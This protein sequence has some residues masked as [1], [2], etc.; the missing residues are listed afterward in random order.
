MQ[1]NFLDITQQGALGY[2]DLQAQN[3]TA[4][5]GESLDDIINS[6]RTATS[7]LNSKAQIANPVDPNL[8]SVNPTEV[9]SGLDGDWGSSMWDDSK[10]SVSEDTFNNNL[11]DERA[12]NQWGIAQ[13]GAGLG[14]MTTTGLTTL[15]NGTVGT[16][17]GIG[18][19]LSNLADDDENTGFMQGLWD[20]EF[21]KAMSAAQEKMEEVLPNYYSQEELESPWYTNVLSANFWGDKV[22]KNTGFT[23]GAIGAMWLTGG[24]GAIT[25]GLTVGTGRLLAGLAARGG[26]SLGTLRNIMTGAGTTGKLL[27]TLVNAGIAANG[28]ASFEAVNAV[29]ENAELALKNLEDKR[30]SEIQQLD[31][32]ASDYAE[33]IAQINKASEQYKEDIKASSRDLGNFVWGCNMA[34]LGLSDLAE[35][36]HI[37]QGGYKQSQKLIKPHFQS[38][39]KDASFFDALGG[40]VKG[41]K[42]QA[43]NDV[44]KSL[45]R[46]LLLTGKNALSE[47]GE[48]SSQNIVSNSGQLQE[49]ALLNAKAEQYKYNDGDT[50]LGSRI[51]PGATADLV[52]Y[53][54]AFTKALADQFGG[55]ERGGWEEGF[56]GALTGGAGFMSVT[57][58]Q[59]KDDKGELV[60]GKDGKPKTK[61]AFTWEGGFAEASRSVENE[62]NDNQR[63][64]DAI[65]K[66]FESPEFKQRLQHTIA[67]MDFGQRMDEAL[68][69]GDQFDFKNSE[70]G[71]LVEDYFFFRD[72]G[73]VDNLKDKWKSFQNIDDQTLSQLYLASIDKDGKTELEKKE[74][75]EIRKK[76][77]DKATSNLQKIQMIQD[78]FDYVDAKFPNY[79]DDFKYELAYEYIK[80]EDAKNRIESILKKAN[81]NLQ[82]DVSTMKKLWYSWNTSIEQQY[83]DGSEENLDKS[84]REDLE[85]LRRRQKRAF[86]NIKEYE[87]TPEKL[88]TK[89]LA[90]K[91]AAAL[92]QQN[93]DLDSL[94]EK[95]KGAE[96]VG[97]VADMFN[98]VGQENL[99]ALWERAWKT[100]DD[101]VRAKMVEWDT[102]QKA[103]NAM[104]KDFKAFNLSDEHHNA[105]VNTLLGLFR[106]YNYDSDSLIEAFVNEFDAV[107]KLDYQNSR[108]L[109]AMQVDASTEEGNTLR[110]VLRSLL[111]RSIQHL[112]ESQAEYGDWYSRYQAE[113][114]HR[115]QAEQQENDENSEEEDSEVIPPGANDEIMRKPQISITLDYLKS[116]SY[117]FRDIAIL[118]ED[119]QE[120]K[121]KDI[122]RR[123]L[124]LLEDTP[125]WNFE[126]VDKMVF[127]LSNIAVKQGK[128]ALTL[129]QKIKLISA[130]HDQVSQNSKVKDWNTPFRQTIKQVVDSYNGH[131]YDL[132]DLGPNG[133]LLTKAPDK[134]QGDNNLNNGTSD[135]YQAAKSILSD[136]QMKAY[137]KVE[138]TMSDKPFDTSDQIA[139]ANKVK[140]TWDL[141][142]QGKKIPED[143]QPIAN[144]INDSIILVQGR[145]SDTPEV[146]TLLISDKEMNAEYN[147]GFD[148]EALSSYTLKYITQESNPEAWK[149]VNHVYGSFENWK[150]TQFTI[151]NY[152]RELRKSKV[153][154]LCS[155]NGGKSG[156]PFY[157]TIFTAVKYEGSIVKQINEEG[158]KDNVWIVDTDDGQYLIIG[159]IGYNGTSDTERRAFYKKVEEDLAPTSNETSSIKQ[160]F[161]VGSIE[162]KIVDIGDG[163]MIDHIDGKSSGPQNLF[164]LLENKDTN[165][166]GLT[167]NDL[168]FSVYYSD[169]HR[170]TKSTGLPVH[171][172]KQQDESTDK[173]KVYVYIP[174]SNGQSYRHELQVSTYNDVP[175]GTPLRAK[176]EQALDNILSGHSWTDVLQLQGLLYTE[177]N[178]Y[179][180]FNPTSP[181]VSWKSRTDE[182][183]TLPLTGSI[184]EQKQLI[185]TQVLPSLNP[186]VQ[187]TLDILKNEDSLKMLAD[188]NCLNTTSAMMLGTVGANYTVSMHPEEEVKPT[189]AHTPTTV[190]GNSVKTTV[191]IDGIPV[192]IDGE[193]AAV[194]NGVPLSPWQAELLNLI[195][196]C[197]AG[198]YEA[199]QLVEKLQKKEKIYPGRYYFIPNGNSYR[200][201]HQ[202]DHGNWKEILNNKKHYIKLWKE[203][204]SRAAQQQAQ[205]EAASL[206]KV[207]TIDEGPQAPVSVSTSLSTT[208]IMSILTPI[209]NDLPQSFVQITE[210]LKNSSVVKSADVV[211]SVHCTP[212]DLVT[213]L[214]ILEAIGAVGDFDQNTQSRQV[215]ASS[216][217]IQRIIDVYNSMINSEDDSEDVFGGTSTDKPEKKKDSPEVPDFDQSTLDTIAVNNLFTMLAFL[218]EELEIEGA[219]IKEWSQ[220]AEGY[221]NMDIA[222]V[223]GSIFHP[224]RQY[225]LDTYGKHVDEPMDW[226]KVLAQPQQPE[227]T[228][229]TP[230]SPTVIQDPEDI[231][232]RVKGYTGPTSTEDVDLFGEAPQVQTDKKEEAYWKNPNNFKDSIEKQVAINWDTY[233]ELVLRYK[234]NMITRESFLEK[235][236]NSI[237]LANKIL[238]MTAEYIKESGLYPC[239]TFTQG[240]AGHWVQ[241]GDQLTLTNYSDNG[242]VLSNTLVQVKEVNPDGSVL[243][244]E[245]SILPASL[246]LQYFGQRS[247]IAKGNYVQIT[248]NS[249]LGNARKAPTLLPVPDAASHSSWKY[250]SE[251]AQ[252]R[253]DKYPTL[254]GDSLQSTLQL[255]AEANKHGVL[256]NIVILQEKQ[257]PNTI[258]SITQSEWDRAVTALIELGFAN[259]AELAELPVNNIV[260]ELEWRRAKAQL[261]KEAAE[262]EKQIKEVERIAK[263]KGSFLVES[264]LQQT[265]TIDQQAIIN[266]LRNNLIGGQISLEAFELFINSSEGKQY[267]NTF[268]SEADKSLQIALQAQQ[269]PQETKKNNQEDA[270]KP[271]KVLPNSE[272]YS[273]FEDLLYDESN[274]Y[275]EELAELLESELQQAG[276][277]ADSL[278]AEALYE[279]LKKKGIA[280]ECYLSVCSKEQFDV[281]KEIIKNC[282]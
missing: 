240:S 43:V 80:A 222:N 73:L 130:I 77:Q 160:P 110:S 155:T 212:D 208:D 168:E 17:Y 199:Q 217:D 200:I 256:P 144:I 221:L 81:P 89:L 196:E 13:L 67:K 140:Q 18:Q 97:Q 181:H 129:D 186:R 59:V 117:S 231:A 120:S 115:K 28:E 2:K 47:F 277:D 91:M 21:T 61:W 32:L 96:S 223:R 202:D 191:I 71:S 153:K 252:V 143:L 53:T 24:A 94:I 14:K 282:R 62:Y 33:K 182:R 20:N 163:R 235:V 209:I 193:N 189:V 78:A 75:D 30:V 138:A 79:S 254:H 263:G 29:K 239:P 38:N 113:A 12:H 257:G 173:G 224:L 226:S 126:D 253:G 49:Q 122:Q 58:K 154:F 8:Y 133:E 152:L 272:N 210:S 203:A 108:F 184:E 234:N 74:I 170:Y 76:Y 151:D 39:G 269:K 194:S 148:V 248:A 50:I 106:E 65:N 244:T 102:V 103:Q 63:L 267:I 98:S 88:M 161:H 241:V 35:F 123:S 166:R 185:L 132:E 116:H 179:F 141:I 6:Y 135:S 213:T 271:I 131:F 274:P 86:Q 69:K 27:G 157:K 52:N 64:V 5:E 100:G 215:L 220:R 190:I 227:S 41:E 237:T 54:N 204:Q 218:P 225:Y 233:L 207:P 93:Q 107:A 127:T 251:H 211:S 243:T 142:A 111:G 198:N 171:S 9:T 228:P 68:E 92:K 57:R 205:Q 7:S 230:S 3:N 125:N 121:L 178:L 275:M 236:G 56:L 36:K 147:Q 255:F 101:D 183:M 262:R 164:T 104:Y 19:G 270:L 175:E 261:V 105:F 22:L 276:V 40:I 197:Q 34:I 245:N 150:K 124:N 90:V 16:L 4:F 31:P 37:L 60:Y 26:A 264:Y 192:V 259:P 134:S 273:T 10:H 118:P 159:S 172:N 158:N 55:F 42:A 112:K 268:M 216:E 195:L 247:T 242:D 70:I 1:D 265:T 128:P 201:I 188:S 136:D 87:A 281:L 15:L 266:W 48:E 146:P 44:D 176:I 95:I 229:S 187:I 84:Q 99:E 167:I 11:Q 232:E 169:G 85:K 260:N 280:E 66:R 46:K 250:L 214:G 279:A 72:M 51:N 249:R 139:L 23:L 238:E 114:E 82:G 119:K 258:L 45:S 109:Q 145:P 25:E 156:Q 149:A 165:P 162:T 83:L 246:I 206:P 137:K 174:T 180:D 219:T 278:D 177:N